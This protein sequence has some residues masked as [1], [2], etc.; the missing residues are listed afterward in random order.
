MGSNPV[1]VDDGD[2]CTTDSCDPVLGVQHVPVT[3]NPNCAQWYS[4][5]LKVEVK[6]NYYD[7]QK[8]QQY[9]QVTNTGAAP[10]NLSD[11]FDQ[12]LGL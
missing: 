11:I 4:G 5:G 6:T 10:V 12:V 1:P 9:F 2:P 7:Q 8:A 3:D